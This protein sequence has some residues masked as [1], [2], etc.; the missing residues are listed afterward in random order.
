MT[1]DSSSRFPAAPSRF[2]VAAKHATATRDTTPLIELS[3]VKK[4]YVNGD[5]AVEVLHGIDLA[6]NPG[7]LVAIMGASGS[8]KSTLMNILGCLDRPTEGSYK[9]MGRDVSTLDRDQLAE[10]RR[11]SFGFVFQS[12]NLIATG[13]ATDNVEMPAVYAGLSPAERHAR[14][15]ELLDMLGLGDRTHHRPNQLSGG[16]QQ[17]V[18]IARALMNGGRVILADEPTGAL[19]SKSGAEVMRKLK[20]LNAEGHTVILITHAREVAEHAPR[21]I[22]IKDGR[23]VADPGP[24]PPANH[25]AA[26]AW[27]PRRGRISHGADVAEATKTA[28]RA[29]ARQRIPLGADVA[30]HRD[31]RRLR[32]RDARDRRRRQAGGDRSH[33]RD[34]LE[35][36]AGAPRCAEPARL[37]E[38]RDA[39]ALGRAGDR[40]RSAQCAGR[41][42]RTEQHRHACASAAPTTRAR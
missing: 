14:A 38:H 6:I 26:D 23:I 29:S 24:Q 34:G 4:T 27:Q 20:D 7:E 15:S 5:L 40:P 36:V 16:Q 28:L 31:R 30:R 37:S 13:T 39:G 12:Y 18:S 1:P 33:Q 17:R 9:F 42:S 21:V 41:D 22:E 32:D 10:L 8:G 19:D 2:P 35:P 11:E 25:N 3:G